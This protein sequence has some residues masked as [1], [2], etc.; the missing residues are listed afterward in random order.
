MKARS[1]LYI[2]SLPLVSVCL[3]AVAA[4]NALNLRY[5][6]NY[7]LPAIGFTLYFVTWSKDRRIHSANNRFC[8]DSPGFSRILQD[9]PGLQQLEEALPPS[10]KHTNQ[11]NTVSGHT[12]TD[13]DILHT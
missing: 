11:V 9:S 13:G 10:G 1:L 5:H 2:G 7:L 6:N 3:S 4:C 12:E 8:V